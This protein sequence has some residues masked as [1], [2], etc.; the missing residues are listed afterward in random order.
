MEMSAEDGYNDETSQVLQ[1]IYTNAAAKE[2]FDTSG[3]Q[4][5]H[6]LDWEDQYKS[7]KNTYKN[8]LRELI[9]Q[10]R[11][12]EEK[13]EDEVGHIIRIEESDAKSFEQHEFDEIKQDLQDA[14]EVIMENW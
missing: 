7:F 9:R 12:L 11:D 5:V 3:T 4:A 6:V 14:F 2:D 13:W 8:K 1:E 10:D